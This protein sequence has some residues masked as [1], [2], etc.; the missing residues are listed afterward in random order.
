MPHHNMSQYTNHTQQNNHNGHHIHLPVTPQAY[1]AA[2]LTPLLFARHTIACERH[3]DRNEDSIVVDERSGLAAVFDGVGGSAAGQIASQTAVRATH[4]GWRRVLEQLQKKRKIYDLIANPGD[5]YLC[6]VLEQLVQSADDLVRTEGA[7]RAHTDD[8]A[9]TVAMAALCREPKSH[10]YTLFYAHVGDSRVYLQH[11]NEPLKRLTS[12]DGLLAKL[13][14]N[15]V[16]KDEDAHRIDQAMRAD[17]L[18]DMEFS[19]FRL[20]GGITQAL[21]GPVP[22]TI[23]TAEVAVVPGDRILLCTDGIHDNL[24]DEEIADILRSSP[25]TSAARLLVEH[26]LWRS[27]QERSV[28]VRAKPDD[29]SA[30]VM[31]CRF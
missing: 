23:H 20:R 26:S 29:M 17:Q 14:E 10:G 16:V 1:H 11:E 24:T 25:R 15:Q 19:Y 2:E 28:T 7:Q 5:N 22:P 4:Q 18:T 3:P 27:R 31:T 9:T 12:D 6:S 21:G 13:V 8:L 30:I